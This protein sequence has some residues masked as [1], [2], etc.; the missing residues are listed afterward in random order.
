MLNLPNSKDTRVVKKPRT[1]DS[2]FSSPF[3]QKPKV[4]RHCSTCFFVIG[5]GISH[6]CTQSSFC[7]N[8]EEIASGD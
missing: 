2:S 4:E 1:S 5:V 7:Q 3:D 8:L 6:T